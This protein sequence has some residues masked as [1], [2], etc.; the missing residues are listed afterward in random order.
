[1]HKQLLHL[2]QSENNTLR[3]VIKNQHARLIFLE[4]IRKDNNLKIAECYYVDRVRNGKFYAVPQK[5]ISKTFTYNELLTVIEHELNRKY[6]GIETINSL[7][8]LTYLTNLYL[9][10]DVV[11][12]G[13]NAFY[14]NYRMSNVVYSGSI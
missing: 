5:L 3:A 13:D 1:M 10:G 12:F 9:V 7:S 11:S 2:Y 6:Y 4:L 14:N 8:D